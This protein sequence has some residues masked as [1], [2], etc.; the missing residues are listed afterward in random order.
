MMFKNIKLRQCLG[1]SVLLFGL[2]FFWGVKLGPRHVEASLLF[3]EKNK[4]ESDLCP[5]E[6]MSYLLTPVDIENINQKIKSNNQFY[7]DIFSMDEIYIYSVRESLSVWPQEAQVGENKKSVKPTERQMWVSKARKAIPILGY[8]MVKERGSIRALPTKAAYYKSPAD[9]FDRFQLSAVYP[10]EL[11]RV[12]SETQ[13][14]EYCL[15]SSRFY[16]GWLKKEAL[17]M[18]DDRMAGRLAKA[19]SLYVVDAQQEVAWVSEEGADHAL[20]LPLGTILPHLGPD[21]MSSTLSFMKD[22]HY[23]LFYPVDKSILRI[24]ENQLMTQPLTMTEANIK[25]QANQLLGETYDWGGGW[26]GRD[27]SSLVRDIYATFG[28]YLPRDSVEQQAMARWLYPEHNQA[29]RAL[30]TDKEKLDWIGRLPVGSLLFM[31]GHVMMIYDQTEEQVKVVHDYTTYYT[32][33]AGKLVAVEGMRVGVS[34]LSILD[35]NANTYI[36]QIKGVLPLEKE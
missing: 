26:Q 9:V 23:N 4:L 16:S 30:G 11:I 27:C 19:P 6:T 35:K 29:F 36:S 28:F 32:Q 21:G 17:E 24:K 1:L 20:L 8:A 5:E 31:T 15:I 34:D 22:K 3:N 10:G 12:L 13:D 33:E 7:L 18:V 2:M 25:G 14:G